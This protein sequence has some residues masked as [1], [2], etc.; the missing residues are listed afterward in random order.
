MRMPTVTEQESAIIAAM[1]QTLSR[2][3]TAQLRDGAPSAAL[4]TDRLERCIA[5]LVERRAAIEE[6][7]AAGFGA[8]SRHAAAFA[9]LAAP[10][11]PLKHAPGHLSAWVR[12]ERRATP[13]RL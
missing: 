5:L 1:K 2:Q 7:V 3:R 6:A 13:P 11:G 10:V 8:P 4:R 12:T 9:G